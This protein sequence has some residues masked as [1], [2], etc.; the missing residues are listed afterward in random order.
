ML[1]PLTIST[2]DSVLNHEHKSQ[3]M[4]YLALSEHWRIYLGEAAKHDIKAYVE[5]VLS[6]K[7][8]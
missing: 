4:R 6:S 8:R 3:S 5:V 2:A 7:R 1:Q